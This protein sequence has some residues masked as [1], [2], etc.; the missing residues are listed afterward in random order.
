MSNNTSSVQNT[1]QPVVPSSDWANWALL[2]AYYTGLSQG[3]E[4]AD[5][6][7]LPELI[8]NRF[9]QIAGEHQCGNS[10]IPGP[11]SYV[12]LTDGG[13]WGRGKTIA[14]AVKAAKS[15]T[16]TALVRATLVI[17][18]DKPTVDEW[19]RVSSSSLSMQVYL[20]AIGTVGS[21]LNAN[22]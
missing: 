3:V 13:L 18:D 12:I 14:E 1:K 19:G 11:R 20:G 16:R 7:I 5:K 9:A 21:I 8:I 6:H 15:Y 4:V 10:P 22:K 2:Q 17:N